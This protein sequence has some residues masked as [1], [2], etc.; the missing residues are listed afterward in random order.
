[1]EIAGDSSL[2]TVLVENGSPNSRHLYRPWLED[3]S[4]RG[5]RL[6]GYDRPGYGRSTLHPG[7]TVGDGAADV[8][9]IAQAIGADRLAVMGMSGGGPHALACA[10][11]LPDLVVAAAVIASPAPWGAEGL[12]YFAGMGQDNIDDMKL[13]L[14]DWEASRRKAP[15]D[16][17]AFMQLTGSQLAAGLKTLVSPPDA[18]ALTGELAEFL[19]WSFAEGLAPGWE[20]WWDDGA[21]SMEPWGF[22]LESI[23]VPVKIW[24]GREDRFVPVQHG[25]WLAEHVAGAEAV[26]SDS[27]GHIS[28]I[29]NRV[30]EV[31]DW[32]AGH[33]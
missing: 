16:R 26:I 28:L 18:A 11:L 22:E 6:I 25:E 27:D 14:S 30:A 31:Q 19:A 20:G 13:Y 12:D 15:Q 23:R 7:R 29:A 8:R 3:A 9:A 4:R 2:G 32:L 33:S 10:A 24:H 1:M 5:I 17:E 21:A